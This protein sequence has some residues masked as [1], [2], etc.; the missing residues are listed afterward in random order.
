MEIVQLGGS[1]IGDNGRVVDLAARIALAR[2]VS[3]A[4]QAG[5]RDPDRLFALD[6]FDDIWEDD[7]P[8][9]GIGP[10]VFNHV[11]PFRPSPPDDGWRFCAGCGWAFYPFGPYPA[12]RA[13]MAAHRASVECQEAVARDYPA[14]IG[15]WGKPVVESPSTGG[16]SE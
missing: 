5:S 16:L 2:R 11:D 3:L 10:L 12:Q 8:R 7:R 4:P 9:P 14:W 15:T 13:Q 6:D 1:P